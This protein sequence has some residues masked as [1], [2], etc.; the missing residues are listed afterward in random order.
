MDIRVILS[1]VAKNHA[2]ETAIG[3]QK[4]GW[5]KKFYT[6]FYA[7]KNPPFSQKSFIRLLPSSL[8]SK[9]SNRYHEEL[10]EAL[11]ASYF[12]PEIMERLRPLRQAFGAYQMMNLKSSLFDRRVSL[13]DLS[14][15]V[16]HGFEAAVLYSMRAAKKCGAIAVLDQ[17]IFHHEVS[18][19]IMQEEYANW[20]IAPPPFLKS[21]DT[22]IIRKELE[23]AE[24][25]YVMVPTERIA[26]DFEARGKKAIIVPYGFN[27]QRFQIKAKED[28]VFRVIFVGIIGLRKGVVYLLEAFKQLRLK[29]AELLLISPIDEDFK[30]ILKRYDGTF[31]HIDSVENR[32]LP[33]YYSNS[34]VFVFP[35]L[36][37]GSALVSYEAMACGLPMIATE[38]AGSVARNGEDG[39]IVPIRDIESLKE[40]ILYCYEHPNRSREMG[41][42]AHDHVQNFTWDRYHQE[43][44]NAYRL[45]L[46]KQKMK[47]S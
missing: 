23:I 16:F 32:D 12:F 3:F 19:D 24:A 18:R 35:S 37:E 10:D 34:S 31:K 41:I 11:V 15:D 33:N 25:D 45:M 46:Q 47:I 14:C 17:P 36:V 40:K 6:S 39:F 27:S 13:S 22:N 5:L 1:H 43:L 38:N 28:G 20:G 7:K 44:Q 42:N 30:P 21:R 29:N 8:R 4:K 2:Y 9:M 26:K